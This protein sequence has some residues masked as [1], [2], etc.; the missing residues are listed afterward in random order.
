VDA[1]RIAAL[2]AQGVGWKRIAAEMG[3]GVGTLYRLAREGSKIRERV[4]EPQLLSWDALGCTMKDFR[5]VTGRQPGTLKALALAREK[6]ANEELTA[7]SY[8]R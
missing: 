1:R 7:D 2:R 3:I 4:S 5:V 8:F 6:Q